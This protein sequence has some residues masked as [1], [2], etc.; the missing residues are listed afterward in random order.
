MAKGRPSRY[1]RD[2]PDDDGPGTRVVV[3]L[4]DLVDVAAEGEVEEGDDMDSLQRLRPVERCVLRMSEEGLPDA[5]IGRRLGRSPEHVRRVRA[6]TAVPRSG[7]APRRDH[8]L[9]P[10]ERR[11][12]R[13]RAHGT[14]YPTIAEMFRRS[15]EFVEFVE[16]MAHYKL[17]R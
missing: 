1:R 15:P 17:T 11:V 6:L 13:W 14:G 16:Q 5:E 7:A 10:L 4:G 12:L 2:V 8:P 9:R 3:A